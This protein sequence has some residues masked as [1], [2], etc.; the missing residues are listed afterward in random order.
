[1]APLIPVSY[2]S[3]AHDDSSPHVE[4]LPGP[5][6]KLL[7]KSLAGSASSSDVPSPAHALR[8]HDTVHPGNDSNVGAGGGAG[9]HFQVAGATRSFARVPIPSGPDDSPSEADGSS[10][11]GSVELARIQR[12]GSLDQSATRRQQPSAKGTTREVDTE[13]DGIVDE[14][15][16]LLEPDN[17]HVRVRRDEE[18]NAAAAGAAIDETSS[19]HSHSH[20]S[21]SKGSSGVSSM[22]L[23]GMQSTVKVSRRAW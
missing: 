17:Q 22:G 4:H 9:A 21:G 7:G 16:A 20:A 19:R 3:R 14:G 13:G 8:A 10:R 18:G 23:K 1:M 5:A 6:T 15:L 12:S 11:G 2:R